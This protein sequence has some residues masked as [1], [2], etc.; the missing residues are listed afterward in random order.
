VKT[1]PVTVAQALDD[2]RAARI[3][4]LDAQRLLAHVLSR[5]R[6]W[7]FAHPDAPLDPTLADVVQAAWVRLGDG[8]PLPYVL[9]EQ[10]FH[11]LT[12]TVNRDVLIPRSD[13]EVLVDWALELL[14]RAPEGRTPEVADLGTGSGAIALAIGHGCPRAHVLATDV[15]EAALRVARANAARVGLAIDTLASAWWS[16]LGAR[17]FDLV[18]SN[19][20]YI[21]P[22]DPHLPALRHE[23]LL[24]LTAV[25]QGL[26]DLRQIVRGAPAH[27]AAGGWLLLEHGPDQARAVA[28]LLRDNGFEA[29]ET[30]TDAAGRPRCTGARR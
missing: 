3:D 19:P 13:T 1:Q 4:R 17:H 24:A 5:P 14:G 8:E 30:R 26:G 28:V 21:A 9:G 20:P 12:L 29:I 22:D 6:S 11:G 16:G 10:G 25:E 18:V 7:L 23:P 27:L 15:S 2:A